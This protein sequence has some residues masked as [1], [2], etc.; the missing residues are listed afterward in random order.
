MS[1]GY[2]T[3]IYKDGVVRETNKGVLGI[4]LDLILKIDRSCQLSELVFVDG[5]E[6][7]ANS[8]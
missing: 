3:Y 1:I 7:V 6:M 5:T 2:S 8:D 4:V